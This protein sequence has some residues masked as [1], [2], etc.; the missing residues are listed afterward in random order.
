MKTSRNKQNSRKI[1]GTNVKNYAYN[2]VLVYNHEI[3][4]ENNMVD[5]TKQE[6]SKPNLV[7]D[8]IVNL[9]DI[10]VKDAV[11]MIVRCN[12]TS[13]NEDSQAKMGRHHGAEQ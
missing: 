1:Q 5:K 12:L 4:A 2:R 7:M 13:A 10:P 6:N 3:N 9:R 8:L 11:T